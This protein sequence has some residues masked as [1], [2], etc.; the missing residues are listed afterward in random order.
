MADSANPVRV[1]IETAR[2][3]VIA[4]FDI[5]NG[6]AQ[7]FPD[8][9]TNRVEA[10][11]L[12]DWMR[13]IHPGIGL[14]TCTDCVIQLDQRCVDHHLHDFN[15]ALLIGDIFCLINWLKLR[16]CWGI[17]PKRRS[18]TERRWGFVKGSSSSFRNWVVAA[19]SL[20]IGSG[21][22]RRTFGPKALV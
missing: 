20:V 11:Q 10:A 21:I 13:H 18:K 6:V 22:A 1:T 4:P 5:G 16:S 14:V 19:I 8:L 15:D 17:C 9:F 3:N 2:H 12:V 7:R